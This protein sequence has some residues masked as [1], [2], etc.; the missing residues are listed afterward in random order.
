MP[1]TC[2]LDEQTNCNMVLAA[3][4]QPTGCDMQNQTPTEVLVAAANGRW[5][6]EAHTGDK[7]HGRESPK[8]ALW[9]ALL[10]RWVVAMHLGRRSFK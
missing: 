8:T 4:A 9:A 1:L 10:S 7:R 6:L 2:C 3:A 5:D